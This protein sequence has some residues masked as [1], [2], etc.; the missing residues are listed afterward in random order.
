[1]VEANRRMTPTPG[2]TALAI[3]DMQNAFCHDDGSMAK[4][5][6]DIT[7]LKAAIDPC[8]RLLIAARRA[9]LPVIHTRIL[10][11][12][13]YADGG[14]SISHM[15]PEMVAIKSLAANTWDIEIVDE[16]KPADTETVI[17]K[18]R[19]SAFYAPDL[20]STLKKR[21]IDSLVVCGVTTNC[22]VESTVRDAFQR[23]YKTFV[24]KDAVG[25][26]EAFRHE[27][28]LKTMA[29]LFADLVSV[30]EMTASWN[31]CE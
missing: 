3:I 15:M 25:E 19:F 21:S 16:L 31:K 4:L 11:Q 18:N 30:D 14:L 23:N 2:R 12:T 9:E 8:R 5:G 7:M 1:M 22:C 27:A 13:D 17:D 20:E 28:S 26:L 29:F 6:L 10:Y 24:V